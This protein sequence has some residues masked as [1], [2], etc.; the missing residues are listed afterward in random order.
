MAGRIDKLTNGKFCTSINPKD[1]HAI[2]NCVDPREKR[3]LELVMLIL[4]PEK[5]SRVTLTVGNTIFGTLCGFRK[6]NWR[7]V[8]Q[9]IVDMLVS[10]L[11]KEKASPISLY[12]FHLYHK[13]ECL[14]EEE[15]Q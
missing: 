8:L 3:V 2:A 12:L 4:Y 1:R 15:M 7:Q 13:F 6:V 9:E 11:V 10:R 5:P 14:R